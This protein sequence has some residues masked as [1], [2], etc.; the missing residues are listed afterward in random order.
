MS[1]KLYVKYEKD[2]PGYWIIM[3]QNPLRG[4]KSLLGLLLDSF[5]PMN[6]CIIIDRDENDINRIT[7]RLH[8]IGD[9]EDEYGTDAV[10]RLSAD[11]YEYIKQQWNKV[12]AQ[13]PH[14]FVLT[15]NDHGWIY[16]ELKNELKSEDMQYLDVEKMQKL[17]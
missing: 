12:V 17:S 4:Q 6:D 14:Y 10:L 15:R 16:L 3:S 5:N 9:A 7:M 13:R 2:L 8:F 11:N 1:V